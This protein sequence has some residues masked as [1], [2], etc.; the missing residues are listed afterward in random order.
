MANLIDKTY[1][2][3][4]TAIAQISQTEVQNALNAM[5]D[6]LE[7][8]LLTLLMGYPLYKDF[9]AHIA[10]AKY[11]RLKSGVEYVNIYGATVKWRGLLFTEGGGATKRSPIANY[12]YYW[13]LRQNATAT[14]GSGEQQ[15]SDGAMPVSSGVKQLRTWNEMVQWNKE[16]HE[17]LW[18][19]ADDYPEYQDILTNWNSV[20]YVER[21]SLFTVINELGL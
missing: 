8:K 14:T 6:S 16:L 20:S 19:K 11:V 3:E 17:F 10:D 18:S 5:I 7:P 21:K 13:W 2:N 4:P 1:F 9:L 12:V 15:L